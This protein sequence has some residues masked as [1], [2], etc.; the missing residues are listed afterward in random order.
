MGQCYGVTLKCKVKDKDGAVSAMKKQ[1]A[2]DTHTRYNLDH[3]KEIG[4]DIDTFEGLV[5]CVFAGWENGLHTTKVLD[6]GSF[7]LDSGFDACYGW[8][9]VMSDMFRAVHVSATFNS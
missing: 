1:M 5:R 2:D 3:F 4:V 7:Y 6:D 8:E 9:I